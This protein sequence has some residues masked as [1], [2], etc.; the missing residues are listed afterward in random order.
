METEHTV[1]LFYTNVRWL[2]R[3][4][5]FNRLFELRCEVLAFMKNYDKNPIYAADLESHQ[6]LLC[7]AYLADIFSALIDLCIFL[8]GRG[9]DVISSVEKSVQVEIYLV[10]EASSK[11]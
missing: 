9:T 2:S 3:G 7:L 1:L 8:Q 5:M 6:F 10:V 4:K 11:G